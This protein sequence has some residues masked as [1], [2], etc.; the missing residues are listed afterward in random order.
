MDQ[1]WSNKFDNVSSGTYEFLCDQMS[2]G[3]AYVI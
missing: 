3:R 1:T 2:N